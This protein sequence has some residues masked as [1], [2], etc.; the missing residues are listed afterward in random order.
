MAKGLRSKVEKRNRSVLRKTVMMPIVN[1]RRQDLAELQKRVISSNKGGNSITN[2]KKALSIPGDSAMDVEKD[3]QSDDE[4]VEDITKE[5]Y[6]ENKI[7][8]AGNRV[9]SQHHRKFVLIKQPKAPRNV[10]STKELVWFK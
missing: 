6:G 10:T 3:D 1:K 7:V 4:K 2:I 8:H 5:S 9:P